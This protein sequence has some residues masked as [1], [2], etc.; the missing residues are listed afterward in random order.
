M[1]ERTRTEPPARKRQFPHDR[2]P[3]AA[4]GISG[5]RASTF[6][7]N[8]D[9]KMWGRMSAAMPLPVSDTRST[10][11]LRWDASPCS[12]SIVNCPPL[13]HGVDGV[14]HQVQ[15]DA[16][17][18]RFLQRRGLGVRHNFDFPLGSCSLPS[19]GTAALCV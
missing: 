9:S 17:E 11:G 10:S 5:S 2:Q 15:Q 14:A 6:V 13:G 18:F 7:E 16:I 4:S 1:R 8:P 3:I 19:A 12:S